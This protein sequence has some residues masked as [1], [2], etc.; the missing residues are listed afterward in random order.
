MRLVIQRVKE[1]SVYIDKDLFSKIKHGLLIYLGIHKEDTKQDAIKL[2][3][4]VSNLRIFEDNDG[5]MN[6]NISAI[7]GKFLVVSQFTLYGDTNK[8]NRPSFI[9]AA[10]PK[11]AIPIYETFI[12]ELEKNFVVKTGEFGANMDISS[13]NDG[14]VTIIIDN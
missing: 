11:H 2:A 10:R 7:D 12:K 9:E 3:K 1:A 14:P 13:I 8:G 6:L 4:K 5:K